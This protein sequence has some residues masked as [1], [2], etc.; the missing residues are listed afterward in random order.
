MSEASELRD[1]LRKAHEWMEHKGRC[2]TYASNTEGGSP[3][4]A[5]SEE[6][7]NCGL[8]RWRAQVKAICK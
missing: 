1:L 8:N 7:C 2:K 4:D 5:D 6:D 3:Y